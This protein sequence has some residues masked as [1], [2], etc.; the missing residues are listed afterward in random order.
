MLNFFYNFKR[1]LLTR[2]GLAAILVLLAGAILRRC[3]K[4]RE[5]EILSEELKTGERA[6]VI[7]GP[8]SGSVVAITNG[9]PHGSGVQSSL[10]RGRNSKPS[11]SPGTVIERIDGARGI[12]I[13]IGDTGNVSITAR[14]KGFCFEPGLGLFAT[15]SDPRIFIDAQL[16]FARRH[17][18]NAGIGL[19]FRKPVNGVAFVAYSYNFWSNTS[20]LVGFDTKNEVLL[21]LRVK[22]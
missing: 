17:G 6:A 8:N 3:D 18:A 2:A 5:K 16:L 7:V 9:A 11:T 15:S 10:L 13:S 1:L 12:R 20:V 21:G 19:G 14:T 4:N 22:F